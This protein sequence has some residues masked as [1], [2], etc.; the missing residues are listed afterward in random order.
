MA[1]VNS[2][3][4]I[5]RP[6]VNTSL[7]LDIA[8][9]VDYRG[10]N[11]YVDN[12]SKDDGQFWHLIAAPGGCRVVNALSG[13][14][15]DLEVTHGFESETN[16]HQFDLASSSITQTWIFETDGGTATIDGKSYPT[17]TIKCAN[18]TSLALDV[19][20]AAQHAGTNVWVYT[21][22]GTDAQRFVLFDAGML[23][24]GWYTVRPSGA[25]DLCMGIYEERSSANGAPVVTMADDAAN[26][27]IWKVITDTGTGSMRLMNAL[28]RR[29]LR[30]D[31]ETPRAGMPLAQWQLDASPTKLFAVH[32][33]GSTGGRP[34]YRLRAFNGTGYSADCAATTG[35]I[36]TQMTLEADRNSG[37]QRFVFDRTLPLGDGLAAPSSWALRFP[38]TYHYPNIADQTRPWGNEPT[39]G[40]DN[41]DGSWTVDF[42]LSWVAPRAE[43]QVRYRLIATDALTGR[44]TTGAWTNAGNGST[45]LDGWGYPTTPSLVASRIGTRMVA[46]RVIPITIG[47]RSGQARKVDVD[48]QGRTFAYNYVDGGPARSVVSSAKIS[49][50]WSDTATIGAVKYTGLGLVTDVTHDYPVDGVSTTLTGACGGVRVLDGWHSGSMP[51]T[52]SVIVPWG[53]MAGFVAGGKSATVD[54]STLTPDSARRSGKVWRTVTWEQSAGSMPKWVEPDMEIDYDTYTAV[55]TVGQAQAVTV[56]AVERDGDAYTMGVEGTQVAS[57]ADTLTY[58]FFPPKGEW[59]Y[60]VAE[61]ASAATPTQGHRWGVYDGAQ[62][63]LDAHVWNWG[64]NDAAVLRYGS[65]GYPPTEVKW[66]GDVETHATSGRRRPLATAG[67]TVKT[68][69]T[70]EGAAIIGKQRR[71]ET[72][73]AFKALA[74][75]AANGERVLYRSPTGDMATVV[76]TSVSVHEEHGVMTVSVGMEEVD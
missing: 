28:S 70:V 4:Y 61:S 74:E 60:M 8:G 11:V 41:G 53:D 25:L 50:V 7:A 15:L 27:V 64:L 42:R 49:V 26:H 75:T 55:V 16:V 21:V 35:R 32:Q 65:G 59:S 72:K 71:T 54:W 2:G 39:S 37:T 19:R 62:M 51:K 1:T 18:K 10:A 24:D 20:N 46:P 73:A 44:V 45:A 47:T 23:P 40:T 3:T 56:R 38:D 36:K 12:F 67:S 58:R 34:T 5:I 13:K 29:Y 17:Y 69:R 52:S 22:N 33:D 66:E 30:L 48:V 14:V 43:A 76:I 31:N 57:D 9:D 6:V 68:T 63:T